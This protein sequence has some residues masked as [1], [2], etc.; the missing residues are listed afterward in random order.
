MVMVLSFRSRLTT[1]RS[2]DARSQIAS[3]RTLD[4]LKTLARPLREVP[5]VV[6]RSI[7]A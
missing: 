3:G 5:G 6:G 7:A 1:V 2:S 4:R